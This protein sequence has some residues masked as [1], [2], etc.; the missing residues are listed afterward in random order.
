MT[1]IQSAIGALVLS[2]RRFP[3]CP[4]ANCDCHHKDKDEWQKDCFCLCHFEQMNRKFGKDNW[5]IGDV[6]ASARAGKV[7]RKP[8]PRVGSKDGK[9]YGKENSSLAKTKRRGR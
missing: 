1:D 4:I 3:H 2:A 8:G 6:G 5:N 7:R 9:F